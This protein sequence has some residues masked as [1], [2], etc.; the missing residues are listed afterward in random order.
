MLSSFSLQ[1]DVVRLEP[2]TSNHADALAQAAAESRVA[3]GYTWVP[4]GVEDARKYVELALVGQ[5]RGT[6]LPWAIRRRGDDQI[7]GSTRF[8]NL[9]VFE[10]PAPWPPGSSGRSASDEQLPTVGEIGSTWYAESARGTGLNRRVKL[11]Q[12]T[13]AFEEWEVERITIKTDARNSV[14]RRAIEGLGAR[15][16]GVLRAHS[17]ATDGGIRDTAFFS[18]LRS[19]WS[20]VRTAL[21][22]RVW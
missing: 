19:E 6:A 14:S 16:D 15:F 11:L 10:W 13:H 8:L 18:I 9:E 17:P 12:L 3:Y 4:D 20:E 22:A 5:H 1:D 2:L 7:V 21:R